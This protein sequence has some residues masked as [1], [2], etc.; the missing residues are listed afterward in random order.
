M[1]IEGEE[2][3]NR[4]TGPERAKGATSGKGLNLQGCL[5]RFEALNDDG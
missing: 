4:D 3:N 1:F 5:L 2:E